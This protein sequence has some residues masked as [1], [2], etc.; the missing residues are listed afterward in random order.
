MSNPIDLLLNPTS[1]TGKR[2]SLKPTLAQSFFDS[3]FLKPEHLLE[4]VDDTCVWLEWVERNAFPEEAATFVV[5]HLNALG[6]N[7]MDEVGPKAGR[8]V[9]RIFKHCTP[10]TFERIL[11]TLS[12]DEVDVLHSN[13]YNP[14]IP[15]VS[16]L[17]AAQDNTALVA[18]LL[19]WGWNLERTNAQ[20]QT[21]LLQAIRW[22]QALAVLE[23]GA[24]P[25][26]VD[27]NKTTAL[28]RVRNWTRY[29][30]VSAVDITKQLTKYMRNSVPAV[31]PQGHKKQ[32][33]L[34]ALFAELRQDKTGSLK[35]NLE[36]LKKNGAVPE[37]LVAQ[38]GLSLVQ[39]AC[40]QVFK[41]SLHCFNSSPARFFSRFF[42]VMMDH[43][44]DG[45]L[46]DLDRPF[47]NSSHWTDRDV[48]MMMVSTL[49]TRRA[50]NTDFLTSALNQELKTWQ[51]QRFP[52]LL[53]HLPELF[54]P[55]M[56]G[57]KANVLRGIFSE[58]LDPDT[59]LPVFFNK[60]AKKMAQLPF[61]HPLVQWMV[62][63]LN[64]QY[65]RHCSA[66]IDEVELHLNELRWAMWYCRTNTLDNTHILTRIV[67][68]QIM[69][70]WSTWNVGGRYEI[71]QINS[72]GSLACGDRALFEE[73][74]VQRSSQ[75][76]Q[77]DFTLLQT[78]WQHHLDQYDLTTLLEIDGMDPS[79]EE[80]LR[81][82]EARMLRNTIEQHITSVNPSSS[83]RK[84]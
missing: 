1:D 51:T 30:R 34:N 18:V 76:E 54:Q 62:K 50:F 68:A 26:A 66:R 38:D 22:E 41:Q 25:L 31:N 47:A 19:K 56:D 74:I 83:V 4:H 6:F 32:I 44:A 33:A 52:G 82:I 29:S 64:E 45:G 12:E 48:L 43:H 71:G 36:V 20:G 63:D 27:D 49:Q 8:G 13:E 23:H 39:T 73:Y 7:W 81:N 67:D 60:V 84:M 21:S 65:N 58:E 35:K 28:D 77:M 40:N 2:S 11:S 24:N 80:V 79:T 78:W 10:E 70:V 5:H 69:A 61:E 46:V 57:S 75:I 59:V 37:E 3:G 55:V 15:Q 16:I 17:D 9:D 72:Y 53:T 14:Q 42:V